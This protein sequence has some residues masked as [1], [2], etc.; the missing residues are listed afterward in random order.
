MEFTQYTCPVCQQQFENG[1]D[2]VVCPE[3][4]APHHRACYEQTNRC[5]YAD[6]HAEG[7]T[8]N[9]AEESGQAND[10]QPSDVTVCP[11]CQTE[12]EKTAFFCASC[13]FP[14][15]LEKAQKQNSDTQQQNARQT[16]GIPFGFGTAGAPVFD[17]MAG[18][19]SNEPI[20]PNVTAGETAKLIGKNTPY[21]LLVFN[22]I[23]QQGMS[24]FNFSAFVFSG[25]FFIYRKMYVPGIVLA[26]MMMAVIVGSTALM[27]A[28]PWMVNTGY[29]DL[30]NS[31]NSGKYGAGEMGIMALSAGL[32]LLRIAIMLFSGLLANR[33]YY[34]HCVK[35]VETVKNSTAP[36]NVNKELENKGGVNLPMAVSFFVALAVIYELCNLYLMFQL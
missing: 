35:Q 23:K 28:N 34:R 7:F 2:V 12:N 6:R 15:H 25:A 14:L 9:N 8:F 26:L 10:G 31:F 3:C 30:L 13:G 33:L 17:P 22:R 20:A 18:I 4:G 16:Q 1:D 32:N 24:K 36:E 19:D 11:R 21:Y 29:A 5:F 27:M